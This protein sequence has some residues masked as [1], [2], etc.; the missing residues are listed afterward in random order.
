MSA[1]TEPAKTEQHHLEFNFSV[2]ET[3]HFEHDEIV[4][5]TY[6]IDYL[7]VPGLLLRLTSRRLPIVDNQQIKQLLCM[8]ARELCDQTQDQL[9]AAN[10]A[11]K[12]LDDPQVV[13]CFGFDERLVTFLTLV[14]SEYNRT[15]ELPAVLNQG[16]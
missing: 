9:A 12:H 13:Q 2:T 15:G 1:K 5:F 14:M 16:A 8:N 3:Q 10:E 7:P 11:T 6:H 4:G